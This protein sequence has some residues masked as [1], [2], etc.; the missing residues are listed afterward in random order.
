MSTLSQIK[1]DLDIAR[2]ER[3]SELL[4]LLVTL[5]SESSMVGKTKRNG[6]STD[7]EVLSVIRKFKVGVEEIIKIKGNTPELDFEIS[8]Y[9]QYLPQLLSEAELSVIIS[10]IVNEL[11]DKSPKQMGSVMKTLKDKYL[12]RYDGNLASQLVKKILV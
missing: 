5:Y 3:N 12:G 2:R 8:L 9:N 11:P 4:T 7:E 1:S 10:D 6:E